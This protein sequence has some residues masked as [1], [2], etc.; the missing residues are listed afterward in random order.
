MLCTPRR[1]ETAAA[2]DFR[3]DALRWTSTAALVINM[4]IYGK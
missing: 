3:E 2:A 1:L 4:K